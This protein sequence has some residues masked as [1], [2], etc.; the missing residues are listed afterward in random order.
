MAALME[1]KGRSDREKAYP[2]PVMP[3]SVRSSSRAKGILSIMCSPPARKGLSRGTA[4]AR[5]RA[6]TIF[7]APSA[8][9]ANLDTRAARQLY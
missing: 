4:T 7:M 1:P 5:V 8:A 9:P 2:N 6:S 3:S